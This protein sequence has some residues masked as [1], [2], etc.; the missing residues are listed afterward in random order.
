MYN[1]E[2]RRVGTRKIL[3]YP[4]LYPIHVVIKIGV[5]KLDH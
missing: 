3:T 2:R 1:D 5:K 4:C